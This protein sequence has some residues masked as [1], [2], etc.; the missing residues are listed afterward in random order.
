MTSARAV[1][2]RITQQ[3]LRQR[4]GRSGLSHARIAERLITTAAVA[5]VLVVLGSCAQELLWAVVSGA[6]V[7]T[8]GTR[9]T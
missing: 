5:A 1:E 2:Y 9:S 3:L 7:L 6:L 4:E 8:L